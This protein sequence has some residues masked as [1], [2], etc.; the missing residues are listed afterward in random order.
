MRFFLEPYISKEYNNVH[1]AIQNLKVK[2][3]EYIHSFS[4]NVLEKNIQRFEDVSLFYF[5]NRVKHVYNEWYSVTSRSPLEKAEIVV[6]GL[7]RPET[8]WLILGVSKKIKEYGPIKKTIKEEQFLGNV[9][10]NGSEGLEGG[11]KLKKN[12]R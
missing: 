6:S 10:L 4:T 2:I 9:Y 7:R 11:Y 8:S 3:F 1:K 12:L 5:E